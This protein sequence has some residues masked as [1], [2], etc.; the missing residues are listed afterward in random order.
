MYHFKTFIFTSFDLAMS[1]GIILSENHE[2]LIYRSHSTLARCSSRPWRKKRSNQWNKTFF[3]F[4]S[5][6]PRQMR[7][8]WAEKV[9]SAKLSSNIQFIILNELN[10]RGD[11]E[12][13]F[14]LTGIIYNKH[15]WKTKT[16]SLRAILVIYFISL[17]YFRAKSFLSFC[18]VGRSGTEICSENLRGHMT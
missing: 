15:K 18:F 11:K 4:D 13:K 10:S 6:R 7:K 8:R 12:E 16:F 9:F 5:F 17:A 1:N 2:N 3:L 14:S